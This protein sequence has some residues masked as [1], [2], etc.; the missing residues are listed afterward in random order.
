M[1][2]RAL[3]DTKVYKRVVPAAESTIKRIIV[4]KHSFK[5]FQESACHRLKAA[6]TLF[7]TYQTGKSNIKVGV[8]YTNAGG[9]AGYF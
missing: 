4:Q 3:Y 6:Q 9:T 7:V 5:G 1:L 8:F 2:L